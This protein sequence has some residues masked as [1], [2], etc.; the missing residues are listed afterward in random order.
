MVPAL[1]FAL[2]GLIFR[3]LFQSIRTQRR[4]PKSSFPQVSI[5]SKTFGY[6]KYC[7]HCNDEF[8]NQAE[9][10][11]HN[12]KVHN[13]PFPAPRAEKPSVGK[14]YALL[15]VSL[16]A[17]HKEVL[18]AARNA[19]IKAHP[20]RLYRSGLSQQSW[21]KIVEKAKEVGRAADVLCDVR[22]R[23]KYDYGVKKRRA[24]RAQS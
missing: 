7:R 18:R 22:E 21:A 3:Q 4:L 11:N 2:S 13:A 6:H 8:R 23:R 1:Y 12:A 14:Y 20:D 17:S 9:L 16:K 5:L 10:D 15:K 24:R 19:R